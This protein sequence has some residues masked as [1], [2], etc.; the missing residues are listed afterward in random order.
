MVI[1]RPLENETN[2]LLEGLEMCDLLIFE[3]ESLIRKETAPTTGWTHE[4]LESY[5]FDYYSPYVWDAYLG[6]KNQW[7]GSSEV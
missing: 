4:L 6:D 1:T 5:P 3:G 2:D 7:I